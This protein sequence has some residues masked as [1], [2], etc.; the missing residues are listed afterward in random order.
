[1][2]MGCTNCDGQVQGLGQTPAGATGATGAASSSWMPWVLGAVAAVAVGGV[3][4]ATTRHPSAGM[5]ENPTLKKTP[6]EYQAAIANMLMRRYGFSSN[7]AY[8]AVNDEELGWKIAWFFQHNYNVAYAT[9]MIQ[10]R[11]RRK[12]YGPWREAGY[13]PLGRAQPP[14]SDFSGWSPARRPEPPQQMP[15]PG[16]AAERY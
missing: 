1:M 12:L 6:G 2:I 11:A 8:A 3:I 5:H 16:V 15:L 13:M 14:V 4:Y 9:K 10:R 7:K